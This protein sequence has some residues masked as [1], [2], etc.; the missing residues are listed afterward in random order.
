[1]TV[2]TS[3][4]SRLPA[5]PSTWW[6]YSLS[7]VSA[8]VLFWWTLPF[9]GEFTFGNDYTRFPLRQ[10]LELN[11]AIESGSFALF[12]PGFST[13]QTASAATLG[14]I[15]HPIAHVTRQMYGYWDGFAV[16]WNTTFRLLS[17]VAAQIVLFRL[18]RR[19]G[20]Q[21][22]AAFV[23][24][25]MTVYNLRT[26]DL[27]RYGASLES[28]TGYLLLSA[29]LSYLWLDSERRWPW[30]AVALATWWTITSGHPQMAYFGLIGAGLVLLLVPLALPAITG[31]NP[32][33]WSATLRYW[34]TAGTMLGLGALLA[35]GYIVPFYF[36]FLRSGLQ[37]T[38][39]G[40]AWATQWG[41]TP[42]GLLNNFWRPLASDVHGAFGGY[43]LPVVLLT[44][45]A[46]A[47]V[48]GQAPLF[49][50]AG[51]AIVVLILLVA[52]GEHTPV[53]RW[54]WEVAPF[55]EALRGPGRVTQCL[56]MLLLL[57]FV[58]TLHPRQQTNRT[59]L[60]LL[61]G[62]A[63]L[64]IGFLGSRA[65]SDATTDYTPLVVRNAAP[66]VDW[67]WGA[68]AIATVAL[69]RACCHE[70]WQY[71]ARPV[72][73]V[74]VVMQAAIVTSYGT[75]ITARYPVET[76]ALLSDWKRE[77]L[78]Y[79][80]TDSALEP[81]T[82]RRQLEHTFMT[83]FLGQIH[84]RVTPVATLGAA[85]ARLARQR[86][87]DEALVVGLAAAS[88]AS[89]PTAPG[90]LVG[91]IYSQFNRLQFQ[92]GG[93]TGGWFE[94]GIPYASNWTA[95]ILTKSADASLDAGPG[96]AQRETPLPSANWT[97]AR[98]HPTNGNAMG[99]ALPAGAVA[100]DFQY[101]SKATRAGIWLTALGAWLL[102]AVGVSRRRR[103][104]G[105]MLAITGV[106][107]AGGVWQ[108]EHRLYHGDSLRT[109]YVWRAADRP[110]LANLA[111]GKTA[112]A[113]TQNYRTALSRHHPS[114]ANDGH[115][116]AIF[117][118]ET[119]SE[120]G[121]WWQVD[122][123]TSRAIGAIRIFENER[124]NAPLINVRPLRILTSNDGAH[125][126]VVA[127][128]DTPPGEPLSH[129]AP[130][131]A[132]FV[133]IQAHDLGRLV[134]EEVEVLARPVHP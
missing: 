51:A 49:V 23:V 82:A 41:D 47:M 15:W 86:A 61:A 78:D 79:R 30:V 90:A 6:W 24:S 50:Y 45:A 18:S 134:L 7:L 53:H 64:S 104:R 19:L 31:T 128:L 60:L 132:R 70:R 4:S 63:V 5:A 102:V 42:V 85:W 129:A 58:W 115:T 133:R 17:L 109:H 77:S 34:L 33:T 112:T 46:A 93:H 76:L 27:F 37:R 28:W 111:Y 114:R 56:H 20:L 57:M 16:D 22:F 59:P 21:S 91:L 14:Q 127:S 107:V 106:L 74:L 48:R 71:R 92:V 36:E 126:H 124:A 117:T 120:R 43:G 8:F 52:L 121:P 13:G 72:L 84:A 101:Q 65:V 122:L 100:V 35:A 95:R 97:V 94:L 110:P 54:L 99:I 118:A 80:L 68:C 73:V 89:A 62:T 130:L 1:M 131:D 10:Q 40:Y 11:F 66:A 123:G 96:F 12:L 44:L 55:A 98:I 32:A 108:F 125:W 105:P 26:L 103:A 69:L 119:Q 2:S 116:G 25:L 29:S 81:A 39:E 3:D 67:L 9:T 75:W 38:A 83:P 87:P 88:P 113:S